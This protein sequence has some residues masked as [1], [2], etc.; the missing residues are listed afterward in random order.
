MLELISFIGRFNID[1]IRAR[2]RQ[3]QDSIFSH[4]GYNHG[5]GLVGMVVDVQQVDELGP[6]AEVERSLGGLGKV[7]DVKLN[8]R[9]VAARERIVIDEAD[10]DVVVDGDVAAAAA[11]GAVVVA[12][13]AA[14]AVVGAAVVDET[15]TVG[16]HDG[17][18]HDQLYRNWI[19]RPVEVV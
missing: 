10:V 6:E 9:L 5:S 3:E 18:V 12:D 7:G 16:G 19:H 11:V 14:A 4:R 13:D 8:L 17:H 1:H 2:S 15:D